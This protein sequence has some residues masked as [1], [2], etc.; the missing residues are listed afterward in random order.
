M[1]LSIPPPSKDLL[2]FQRSRKKSKDRSARSNASKHCRADTQR[3]S[4]PRDDHG[5]SPK[6]RKT[7]LFKSKSKKKASK[8][9]S[10]DF[11]IMAT[12]GLWDEVSYEEAVDLVASWNFQD[13]AFDQMH[14]PNCINICN[15]QSVGSET[16]RT[17]VSRVKKI[18]SSQ[19]ESGIVGCSI[20]LKQSG[21]GN[22]LVNSQELSVNKSD[23]SI[24][25]CRKLTALSQE[26]GGTDNCTV[27]VVLF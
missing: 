2:K 27:I 23:V 7:K 19:P 25:I 5:V 12:D 9:S 21:S 1:D 6:K 13:Q 24:G 15:E 22:A 26:R 10:R 11:L 20:V 8:H 17:P 16:P 14:I 3:A 4:S 18:E